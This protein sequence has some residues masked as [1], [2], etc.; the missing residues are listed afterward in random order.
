KSY[1]DDQGVHWSKPEQTELPAPDSEPLVARIPSSGDL[2]LLWDN[3]ESHS[4]WPR[5]P[6]ASAISKDDGKT[7][8]SF[9]DVDARQDFDAAY[10]SVFFNGDEA[11]VT[12]YTRPTSWARDSEVT[13]RIFNTK[14]F[15]A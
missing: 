13:L 3:V 9:H 10:P 11:I 14:Q 6:L 2:L 4:N 7:W 15:Y 8:G 5:S 1:S 12:Y